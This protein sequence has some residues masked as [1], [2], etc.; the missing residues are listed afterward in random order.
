MT[1]E[2]IGREHELAL[3]RAFVER[4]ADGLRGVVLVGDPG[5]GKSRLWQHAVD[6]GRERAHTVLTSRPAETERGLPNLVL[7]DLFR[8]LAASLIDALPGPRRRAL[9]AAMLT[10]DPGA[11]PLDAR[12]LGV[13]VTSVLRSLAQERAVLIAIDDDQWIDAPSAASFAFAVRRLPDQ[14]I[15]LLLARRTRGQPA[16]HLERLVE[17][18]ALER[19]EIGALSLGATQLLLRERLG[20]TLPGPTLR[21]LHRVSGGNPFHALE[22]G[23][24]RLR[25]AS[26][27]LAL[28]L[29]EGTVDELLRTRLR[30]FDDATL[31]GL[32]L[33][34]A[35]G[36]TPFEL[37]GT[38]G[39]A[40]EAVDHAVDA[41]V[42]EWSGA[43]IGF[44]HPLLAAAV[45][46][47]AGGERRRAAHQ[48]L[49]AAIDDDV[50]RG[51]HLALGAAEPSATLSG[52]LEAAAD[53]ARGRGQ[54]V[55]AA[56]LAEHA[57]SLTPGDAVADRHRRRLAA[58][59]SRLDAGDGE[60]ARAL[61]SELLH[62]APVGSP[63]AEALLLASELETPATAVVLL[64]DALRA[65][66][67]EPR[68]RAVIHA[69]LASGGRLTRGRS[70][71]EGHVRASRRLA[72]ALVDDALLARALAAAAILRFEA[73]DAQAHDL[74]HEAYR[75]AVRAKDDALLKGVASTIGHLLTWSGETR[76]A[77]AWLMD[78]LANWR[79][80]D[81]VMHSECLWYLALVEL[82]AGRW[83]AAAARA[84]EAME[85][86]TQYGVELPQDHLPAA[87]IALHRGEFEPARRHSERALSLANRMLLPAHLAVLATIES[88]TGNTARAV[89]GFEQAEAAADARGFDEPAQRFW[90][91]EYA[92]ALLRVGR[93]DQ[94]VRLVEDWAATAARVG[95]AREV[96]AAVRVRGLIATATGDLEAAG[97]LLDDACVRHDAAGDRF[98]WARA[99][100]AAGIVHRRLRRK[101]L[102]RQALEAAATAFDELGASSWS[103]E[104]RAELARLGGRRRIEGMSP[105]ERRVAE[106]VAEGRT[107]RDI[108]AALFV[109]ER[110]VASHLTHVYAKLGIRSRTELARFL[111][112]RASNIPTS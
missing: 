66:G 51:R 12:V 48:H 31:R 11:T 24:G 25:G 10:G 30:E 69:A 101:R 19:V 80:R 41:D 87:L 79:D 70:W 107:N 45:Y 49:A 28:P 32:L 47:D 50:L 2:T 33:V 60:R 88:W 36:R 9:E 23:R 54:S 83:T 81:E 52:A 75:L 22:L 14:P 18:S 27:D 105:S 20:L 35:H 91:A 4:P 74:A 97:R 112:D 93:I 106:L 94:T 16:V 1:D 90:R 109:T 84:D 68:L 8:D 85:I 59:R 100:L 13:A 44:T 42:L 40:R 111:S 103:A 39:V 76:R 46:E 55:A 17:P 73:A 92:E 82:S 108:A 63:R 56:D 57:V 71:A 53:V 21:E 65:A 99:R 37:L 3:L 7:G 58:A 86:R 98:G 77:H 29:A 64:D 34:A 110:T 6:I 61:V 15:G 72:T 95:R 43:T 67:S 96:A 89:V 38:L 5:I 62:A 102:A 104:T 26:R 78:Q